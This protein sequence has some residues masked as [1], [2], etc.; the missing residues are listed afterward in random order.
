MVTKNIQ[1]TESSEASEKEDSSDSSSSDVSS[2]ECMQKIYDALTAEGS[3]YAELK[4][5]DTST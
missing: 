4:A 3:D 2:G 5:M 1:N